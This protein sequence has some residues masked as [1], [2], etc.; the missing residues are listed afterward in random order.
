MKNNG[1]VLNWL[2]CDWQHR[3]NSNRQKLTLK[4]YR[5][6]IKRSFYVN[7]KKLREHRKHVTELSKQERERDSPFGDLYAL[8]NTTKKEITKETHTHS[9]QMK[10]ETKIA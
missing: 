5:F 6:G 2:L 9:T 7:C 8:E 4:Q 3:V 1:F 10:N